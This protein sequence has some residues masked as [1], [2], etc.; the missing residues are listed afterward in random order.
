MDRLIQILRSENQTG[1]NY[2]HV[3]PRGK[4][5]QEICI[6]AGPGNNGQVCVTSGSVADGTDY[7]VAEAWQRAMGSSE[8][9]NGTAVK[10]GWLRKSPPLDKKTS[11]FK[12]WEWRWFVLRITPQQQLELEYYKDKDSSRKDEPKGIIK[13]GKA[14]FY[15][16]IIKLCDKKDKKVADIISKHKSENIFT[17]TSS[18]GRT[19]FLICETKEDLESWFDLLQQHLEELGYIK[20]RA[21]GRS[22]TQPC[23]PRPRE[24]TPERYLISAP[25][26]NQNAFAGAG[27]REAQPEPD[28]AV[29][30]SQTPSPR[31]YSS[32]SSSGCSR[33]SSISSQSN[34]DVQYATVYRS[35]TPTGQPPVHHSPT[36]AIQPPARRSPS[37][38]IQR[39]TCLS[40]TS[41]SSLDA[42]QT[43][44]DEDKATSAPICILLARGG[45]SRTSPPFTPPDTPMSPLSST[46]T[47]DF[48]PEFIHQLQ[49]EGDVREQEEKQ[50]PNYCLLHNP[51]QPCCL[52]HHIVYINAETARKHQEDLYENIH[53]IEDEKLWLRRVKTRKAS[54]RQS[55]API[56]KPLELHQG[57]P[58]SRTDLDDEEV[59]GNEEK[60]E[61]EMEDIYEQMGSHPREHPDTETTPMSL[62]SEATVE[63][64][65]SSGEEDLYVLPTGRVSPDSHYGIRPLFSQETVSSTPGSYAVQGKDDSIT[66]SSGGEMSQSDEEDREDVSEIRKAMEAAAADLL[67]D[68]SERRTIRCMLKQENLCQEDEFAFVE[69]QRELL[70]RY[71]RPQAAPK[72]STLGRQVDSR[73]HS[74]PALPPRGFSCDDHSPPRSPNGS[75]SP[76]ALLSRSRSG[77]SG[78]EAPPAD[79]TMKK[80]ANTL[81]LLHNSGPPPLPT[82][83]PPLPPRVSLPPSR[84]SLPPS[85]SE[86]QAEIIRQQMDSAGVKVILSREEVINKLGFVECFSA[87]WIAGWKEKE[88]PALKQYFYV[89]DCV[90][91]IND[92]RVNTADD[93]RRTIQTSMKDQIIFLIKRLPHANVVTLRRTT[94]GEKLGIDIKTNHAEITAVDPDGL[95]GQQGLKPKYSMNNYQVNW[96]I[97]KINSLPVSILAVQEKEVQRRIWEG[98]LQLT[99][100][101]QPSDF[102]K[103][104]RKE[105]KITTN[106]NPK[107][108]EVD[109]LATRK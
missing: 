88:A 17:V 72:A 27:E 19:F 100:V 61:A 89:G 24:N 79:T 33:C 29:Y 76:H 38:T 18:E 69:Q 59:F 97:T 53:V 4:F 104:L 50:E 41:Q 26:R 9:R 85:P 2:L 10:E 32:S 99:L 7:S 95:A 31:P 54:L 93:A 23:G 13:F 46:P 35:A 42:Q 94:D 14:D 86:L 83:P 84:I 67:P 15:E 73:Q 103:T 63:N 25:G 65:Y 92:Q 51:S 52:R 96:T 107:E 58:V 48:N 68:N 71:S 6:M 20:N 43:P 1:G 56:T 11:V 55:C 28:V 78:M 21:R 36:P 66:Q 3:D 105:L 98:G 64:P 62:L 30:P 40:L 37:P 90:Y 106:K 102:I 39:P 108:Y 34:P 49:E 60:E 101:L 16:E 8:D 74:R 5:G 75:H 47:F 57:I 44:G 91:A 82:E 77:S 45:S 22:T 87:V 81:P 70:Q 109:M 80:R 12:A